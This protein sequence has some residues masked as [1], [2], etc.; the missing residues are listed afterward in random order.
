MEGMRRVMTHGGARGQELPN[1]RSQKHVPAIVSVPKPEN[2]NV[3][4]YR[5]QPAGVAIE[6]GRIISSKKLLTNIIFPGGGV[7]ECHGG[8]QRCPPEPQ[9]PREVI[10]DEQSRCQIKMEFIMR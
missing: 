3:N 9:S 5:T 10:P 2:H 1:G 6:A 8:E 7:Q 4:L